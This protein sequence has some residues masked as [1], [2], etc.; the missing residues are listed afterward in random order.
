MKRLLAVPFVAFGLLVWSGAASADHD[1]FSKPLCADIVDANTFY[2]FNGQVTSDTTT[3]VP[4]C[5]G[6]TYS[7]VILVDPGEE[8]TFSARG[9]GNSTS[10]GR[11]QVIVSGSIAG[12]DG[13]NSIC[14]YVT[15]SRGGSQGTNQQ[16]DRFPDAGCT[17]LVPGGSGGSGGHA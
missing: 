12:Q 10:T 7:V 11:G 13:D 14:V 3:S 17:P 6:V 15:S 2:D 8:L 1:D 4:T 5:K 16:F 9:N